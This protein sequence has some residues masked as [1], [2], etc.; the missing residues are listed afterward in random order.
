[1]FGEVASVGDPPPTFLLG[2]LSVEP[3]FLD[4]G[5]HPLDP[6]GIERGAL[7]D[8]F[9]DPLVDV[10]FLLAAVAAVGDDPVA[11]VGDLVPVA[12]VAVD[13]ADDREADAGAVSAAT[14]AWWATS[15]SLP[16]A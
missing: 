2:D 3:T 8:R 12:A 11:V 15:V 10:G 14:I 7:G 9:V 6:F 13:V 16:A 5:A 4:V 1:M